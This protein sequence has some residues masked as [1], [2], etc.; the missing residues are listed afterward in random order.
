MKTPGFVGAHGPPVHLSVDTHQACRCLIAA[1]GWTCYR[2]L[3]FVL[4]VPSHWNVLQRTS[5]CSES[6]L[7]FFKVSMFKGFA[8]KSTLNWL[9]YGW[10]Y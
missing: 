1:I 6:K 7:G 3:P 4:V 5:G 2:M 10:E 9:S 8:L